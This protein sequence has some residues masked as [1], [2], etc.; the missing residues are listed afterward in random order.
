LALWLQHAIVIGLALACAAVFLVRRLRTLG[1]RAPACDGC[2]SGG[3][4]GG[5]TRSPARGREVPIP[6]GDLVRRARPSARA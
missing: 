6:T 2:A 3:A 4:C 5:E 1:G